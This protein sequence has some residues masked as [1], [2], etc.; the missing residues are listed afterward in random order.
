MGAGAELNPVSNRI[1]SFHNFRYIQSVPEQSGVEREYFCFVLWLWCWD[2]MGW[3]DGDKR[4]GGTDARR[5]S[6]TTRA[7][8]HS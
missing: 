4:R 8:K 6:V 5:A 7:I 1:D 2:G 3:D